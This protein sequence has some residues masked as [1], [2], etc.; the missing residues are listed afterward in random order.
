MRISSEMTDLAVIT[1]SNPM[2]VTSLVR[3]AKDTEARLVRLA[4]VL[5]SIVPSHNY[6]GVEEAN[7]QYLEYMA[8]FHPDGQ[9]VP[10]DEGR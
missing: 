6:G 10:H 7:S 8:D 3:N 9:Q 1:P 5:S 2:D 4:G